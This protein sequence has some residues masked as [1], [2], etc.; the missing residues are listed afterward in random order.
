MVNLK[1]R[2]KKYK[3]FEIPYTIIRASAGTV[4]SLIFMWGPFMLK[5]PQIIRF[6]PQWLISQRPGATSYENG[7]PSI[8]LEAIA[9]LESF[10]KEDTKAFEWG[11]GGSTLFIAKR[12]G[13]LISVEHDLKWH[14]LV[15]RLI[16]QHEISNC[17]LFLKKPRSSNNQLDLNEGKVSP[18]YLS[19]EKGGQGFVFEEYCKAIEAY[20]DEHFNL[21]FV[22]GMARPSCIF[23][24]L[25]KLKPGGFLMLD[26]THKVQYAQTMQLLDDWKRKDFFGP[27]PYNRSQ[28]YQTTIWQKKIS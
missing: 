3:I 18:D 26:D 23:H 21:V 28:L 12:V 4:K 9:W 15:S 20:P 6:F 24:A 11:S 1:T 19:S 13:K 17:E 16:K 7:I 8:P 22:D 2:I 14:S 25:R 10:L 5:H 27:K